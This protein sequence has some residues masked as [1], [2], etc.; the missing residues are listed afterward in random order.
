MPGDTGAAALV[1]R[2]G[3]RGWTIAPGYGK[4]KDR[5]FR[6]GHMGDH[7]LEELDEL[8]TVIEEELVD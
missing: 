1:A 4:T 7:T 6:I 5:M 2:L 3:E 8:L